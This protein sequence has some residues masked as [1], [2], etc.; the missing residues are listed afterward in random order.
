MA[1]S[2]A[3]RPCAPRSVRHR[4]AVPPLVLTPWSAAVSGLLLLGRPL[5]ALVVAAGAA[6]RLSRKL[7]RVR[8]PKTTAVRLVALGALG[9]IGQTADAVTRHYWP[10][11]ALGALISRRVRRTVAAIAVGG[12]VLDWWRADRA[13]PPLPAF[14][15]A[16]RLDDLA[17]GAGL[18]WGAAAQ[19]SLEPLR[20]VAPTVRANPKG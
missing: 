1:G 8:H 14:A 4:G 13:R 2:P 7:G 3:T 19:R 20:P 16:R 10:V 12:A 18:W 6:L 5:P 17:Y 15:L 11:A 9:A